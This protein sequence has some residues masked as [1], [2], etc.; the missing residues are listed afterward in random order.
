MFITINKVTCYLTLIVG[1]IFAFWWTFAPP[2]NAPYPF[3]ANGTTYVVVLSS[4]IVGMVI[5]LFLSKTGAHTPLRKIIKDARGEV[6]EQ[7]SV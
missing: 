1:Y 2:A 4:F 6:A 7:L 3:D 5:P